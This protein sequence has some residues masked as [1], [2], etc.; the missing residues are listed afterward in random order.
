[1]DFMCRRNRDATD[2]GLSNC[3][4]IGGCSCGRSRRT[5]WRDVASSLVVRELCGLLLS[6]WSLWAPAVKRPKSPNQPAAP[7]IRVG[8][9]R[10][11]PKVLRKHV[12]CFLDETDDRREVACRES[13][14]MHSPVVV[15]GDV[16]GEWLTIHGNFICGTHRNLV[17][18]VAC[19]A[20]GRQIA[21]TMRVA[22][23]DDLFR[24]GRHAAWSVSWRRRHRSAEILGTTRRSLR[25]PGGTPA[26][27]VTAFGGDRCRVLR[28]ARRPER[29]RPTR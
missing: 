23:T 2:S 24:A 9:R 7:I 6:R 1:M 4:P 18:L 3:Q 29:L 16:N 11:F 12:D 19:I 27:V 17:T 10:R 25:P 5:S 13:V 22:G 15:D 14:V 21:R 8:L 26:A 28:L 20:H